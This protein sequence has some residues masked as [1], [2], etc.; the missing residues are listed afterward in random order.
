MYSPYMLT[1][2]VL[3][4]LRKRIISRH[5]TTAASRHRAP[6]LGRPAMERVI[7]SLEFVP[8]TESD[9]AFGCVTLEDVSRGVEGAVNGDD[10]GAGR[11]RGD[12]L[13][14]IRSRWCGRVEGGEIRGWCG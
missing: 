10:L 13:G 4:A 11:A 2:L 3:P 14:R 6:Q 7:V 1:H 5:L 12:D 9:I 8:A